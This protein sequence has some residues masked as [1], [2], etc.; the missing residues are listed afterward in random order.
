MNETI[1]DTISLSSSTSA[2]TVRLSNVQQAELSL[3]AQTSVIFDRQ[4]KA[5]NDSFTFLPQ[6]EAD[7]FLGTVEGISK[8]ISLR[9]RSSA[10]T[11]SFGIP[12]VSNTISLSAKT[13]TESTGFN[14]NIF[15]SAYRRLRASTFLIN[16]LLLLM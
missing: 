15:T 1:F 10:Q 14:Y 9:P 11:Q 3:V 2:S 13:T 8:N 7:I 4:S 16:I 12:P 6:S 5:I